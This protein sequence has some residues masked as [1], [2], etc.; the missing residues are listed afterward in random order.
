MSAFKKS[1][2]LGEMSREFNNAL[3]PDN[4][5]LATQ[6]AE[7]VT[8]NYEIDDVIQPSEYTET[9]HIIEA[10]LSALRVEGRS[11]KTIAHYEWVIRKFFDFCQIPVSRVSVFHVRRFLEDCKAR[12]NNDR[13]LEDK[14]SDLSSFFKWLHNE[15]IIDRNPMKN[16]GRI[17]YEKT[18]KSVYTKAEIYKLHNSC[19]I[20]RGDRCSEI[21][22]RALLALLES[23]GCRI[24]EICQMDRND[25]DL[26]DR[27]I[28]VLGKGKKER[29][30]YIDRLSAMLV[31]EYLDSRTDDEPALF[32][33]KR[34][35]RLTPGGIRKLLKTI[36]EKAG[37]DGVYPHK[38]RRTLA[39]DLIGHG[40]PL[41]EV[42]QLLGHE[43]INTT[44]E[45]V[46]VD[47]Q[48]VKNS[49]NKYR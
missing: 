33:G 11:P 38:Y 2:M 12:G 41:E 9:P 8:E 21:R 44:M 22:N 23:T 4:A 15:D 39:T 32:I 25:V 36:A 47:Q 7:H 35:N 5:V 24:S 13:T 19:D 27:E 1:Q 10:Y 26:I 42:Q 17:K 37:V 6:I 20:V 45:Y 16:I 31:K 18:V 14:R 3:P 40:M 30:V 28:K 48:M 29:L 49:Y 46:L 43:N 34:S